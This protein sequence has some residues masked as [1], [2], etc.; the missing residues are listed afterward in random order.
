MSKTI[1]S[2]FMD[3]QRAF[4]L[5]ELLLTLTLF[6]AMMALLLGSF[7]QFQKGKS[8]LTTQNA[9]RKQLQMA[10]TL[11]SQ[12]LE[13]AIYA[14]HFVEPNPDQPDEKRKSG[15]QGIDHSFGDHDEDE[16]HLHVARASRFFRGS[17]RPFDPQLHEVSWFVAPDDQGRPSLVRREEYYLDGDMTQGPRSLG[18]GIVTRVR[19]F[20]IKYHDSGDR[21]PRNSWTSEAKHPL[22]LGVTLTLEIENEAGERLRHQFSRNLRPPMNPAKWG[23]P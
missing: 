3:R 13:A 18:V 4:S 11:L 2:V 1:K 15:I 6:G 16:L 10:E 5:L 8:R 14:T 20:D 12:D 17:N 23:N 9:L 22:P 7:F 19:H 21:K